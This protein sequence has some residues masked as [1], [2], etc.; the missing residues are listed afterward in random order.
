ML[1]YTDS[2][3]HVHVPATFVSVLREVSYEGHVTKNSRTIARIQNIEFPSYQ[4][5]D[6]LDNSCKKQSNSAQKILHFSF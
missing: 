4:E 3:I 2:L 1:H 5:G 6:T